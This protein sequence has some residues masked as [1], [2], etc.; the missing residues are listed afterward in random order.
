MLRRPPPTTN[1]LE[2][3][4]FTQPPVSNLSTKG[5]PFGSNR[6]R[7]LRGQAALRKRWERDS[8]V[9]YRAYMSQA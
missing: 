4:M 6:R 8:G 7:E 3:N 5:F 9:E 1:S 2:D